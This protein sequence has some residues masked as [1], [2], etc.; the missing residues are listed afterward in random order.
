[1]AE[2]STRSDP[3]IATLTY[4]LRVSSTEILSAL[5]EIG[6]V[7]GWETQRGD[8]GIGILHVNFET[9][10]QATEAAALGHIRSPKLTQN[11]ATQTDPRD[12]IK[13]KMIRGKTRVP[14]HEDE[15][16]TRLFCTL[17][18]YQSPEA[19]EEEFLRHFSQFGEVSYHKVIRNRDG[20]LR[21]AIVCYYEPKEAEAAL[22]LCNP[23]Y[24]AQPAEPRKMSFLDR[25]RP[26]HERRI[27]H[28]DCGRSI[29]RSTFRLHEAT[30]RML[31]NIKGHPSRTNS[32]VNPETAISP[33]QTL[34]PQEILNQITNLIGI[35]PTHPK[36]D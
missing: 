31:Q 29:D 21:S 22:R 7:A 27:R 24:Q 8:D 17:P 19:R 5:E 11:K 4:D 15:A 20:D 28:R 30:C 10:K 12:L 32:P 6:Q 25:N 26:D 23:I 9:A 35:H 1:M 13:P 36:Q 33:P 18:W 2:A 34:S 16:Y 3:R 14:R